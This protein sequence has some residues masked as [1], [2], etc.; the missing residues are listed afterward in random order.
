[1]KK[2]YSLIL[3]FAAIFGCTPAFALTTYS[4]VYRNDSVDVNSSN[5]LTGSLQIDE[6][7]PLAR[8]TYQWYQTAVSEGGNIPSWIKNVTLTEDRGGVSKTYGFNSGI[9]EEGLMWIP[10]SSTTVNFN[11]DLV[12]QFDWIE[13]YMYEPYSTSSVT[14]GG[15]YFQTLTWRVS[16][17]PNYT[18]YTLISATP[19]TSAVPGPLPIFGIPA[20]LFYSR[21]L[22][23]RIKERNACS[24]IS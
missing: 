18:Y 23:R 17:S 15:L 10:K 4:L 8:N 20:I 12:P 7:D 3:L 2:I 1:M 13:F 24:D 21:K 19:A 16:D 14:G 11:N 5:T 9:G 6:S 22:K